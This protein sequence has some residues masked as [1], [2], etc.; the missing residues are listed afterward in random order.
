LDVFGGA[1][2]S[3]DSA[4]NARSRLEVFTNGQ[5]SNQVTLGQGL[6]GPTDNVGYLYNR[7]NADL[8]FGTND[9]ERMRIDSAGNV[10]IG[11]TAPAYQ[12]ELSTDS[13]GKPATNTWTVS[14]DER[15]KEDIQLADLDQCYDA[16]K[17]IP[18]KR[19]KW[20]DEV[21]SEEQVADR[22]KL[23]WIA[24]D[25]ETVFPKAVGQ[26]ELRY[27]QKYEETV[28]AAI[29]EELDKD[30]NVITAAQPERIE[31]TL[32]SEDVLPDCRSL[33]S[34][35]IYAAMFGTI[36]KL[37]AKVETLEATVASFTK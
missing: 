9:A 5:T 33:N 27:N 6:A 29:P 20:R 19:Y 21:Y 18:L 35:Q 15:I 11:T 4:G 32:I 8:V 36:Q 23:G 3:T 25:V 31:K 22:H 7:A 17:A 2:S 30:G 28:I 37:I 13:A 10:G 24:Q 16:I 14:S 1:I 12:L 34:D 26:R